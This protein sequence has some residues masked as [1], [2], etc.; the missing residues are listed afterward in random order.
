[1]MDDKLIIGKGQLLNTM[2]FSTFG[3]K[4]LGYNLGVVGMVHGL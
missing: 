2:G 3:L 1:M 4:R